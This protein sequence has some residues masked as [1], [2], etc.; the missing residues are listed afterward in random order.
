VKKCQPYAVGTEPTLGE[1]QAYIAD[2][3][4]RLV[5]MLGPEKGGPAD[6][7]ALDPVSTYL[8]V[9]GVVHEHW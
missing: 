7:E 9:Y 8:H 1:T 2:V 4:A 6:H 5:D 3:T